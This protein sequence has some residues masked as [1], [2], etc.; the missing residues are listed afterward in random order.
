[1]LLVLNRERHSFSTHQGFRESLGWTWLP[2]VIM[3]LGYS[4]WREKSGEVGQSNAM[5]EDESF[6]YLSISLGTKPWLG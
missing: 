2:G 5:C 4:R 1:M 6:L 3:G